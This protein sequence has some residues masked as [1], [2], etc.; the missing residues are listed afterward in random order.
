M[1]ANSPISCYE[2]TST[3][4]DKCD[5]PFNNTIPPS[6]HHFEPC[7]GC[8][9]KIVRHRNTPINL[10]AKQY[11]RRTCTSALQINLFMVDHVCIEESNGDGHMCFCESNF[12]NQTSKLTANSIALISVMFTIWIHV[13]FWR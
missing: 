2:C 12:C 1:A 3:V 4:E 9:V 11:I 6:M 13:K 8:C 5:D 10:L 7:E